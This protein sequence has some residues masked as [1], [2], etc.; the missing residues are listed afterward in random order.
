MVTLPSSSFNL[1]LALDIFAAFKHISLVRIS[2]VSTGK[3]ALQSLNRN[4]PALTEAESAIGKLLI[5]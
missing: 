2:T 1:E 4:K 3:G 5:L